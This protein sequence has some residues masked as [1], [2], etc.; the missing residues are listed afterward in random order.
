[1]FFDKLSQ[2]RYKLENHSVLFNT[3]QG[4]IDGF[5]QTTHS[6]VLRTPLGKMRVLPAPGDLAG[7]RR[8][9]VKTGFGEADIPF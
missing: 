1:M 6:T 8:I 7:R 2:K 9:H 4:V 5:D 3:F